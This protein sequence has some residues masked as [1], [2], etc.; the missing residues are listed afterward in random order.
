MND[1]AKNLLLWVIIAV[2]LLTVFQSV[3]PRTP[4]PSDVAY[5][6]FTQQVGN[7]GVASAKF[8]SDRPTKITAKLKDGAV[9][10]TW[11]PEGG[12]AAA[13]DL[14]AKNNVEISQTPP[15]TVAPLWRMRSKNS[16]V[17][18]SSLWSIASTAVRNCSSSGSP[19]A[20][21][22]RVVSFIASLR[23]VSMSC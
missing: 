11:I 17:V 19:N 6:E 18:A 13:I 5:T 3:N 16:R 8:G 4:A 9:V 23:G 2:V 1:M 14:M 10:S 22:S 15:D 7:G 12:N 21:R 20:S